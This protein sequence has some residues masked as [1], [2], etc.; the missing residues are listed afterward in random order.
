MAYSLPPPQP[1]PGWEH[2]LQYLQNLPRPGNFAPQAGGGTIPREPPLIQPFP[3]QPP[4]ILP[5]A[6]RVIA[7]QPSP[8]RHRPAFQPALPVGR[9]LAEGFP[10]G[11]GGSSNAGNRADRQAGRVPDRSWGD[12]GH[13]LTGGIFR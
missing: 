7:P 5:Q 6:P 12:L 3:Y 9:R 11:G 1:V 8:P 13:A 2:I 4:A 10:G